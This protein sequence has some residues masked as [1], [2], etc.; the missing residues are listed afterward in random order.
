MTFIFFLRSSAEDMLAVIGKE[1][2][3]LFRHQPLLQ[4]KVLRETEDLPEMRMRPQ[5][6]ADQEPA[7][8]IEADVSLVKEIVMVAA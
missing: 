6:L 3:A 4:L 7:L 2:L 1:Q 5:L 8:G